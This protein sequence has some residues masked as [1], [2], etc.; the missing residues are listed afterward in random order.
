MTTV[1]VFAPAK[2]NLALHVTGQRA[3]GYHELDTLVT[4]AGAGDHLRISPYPVSSITVEGPEA[5]GVPTD[6]DNLAFKAAWLASPDQGYSILLDK[7]LPVASGIGGGS[8]DAA[9]AFRAALMMGGPGEARAETYWAMPEAVLGTYATALVGLGADVPMCLMSA[10]LRARGVGEKIEFVSL[11]PVHAVL[12]NPRVPVATPDVFRALARKANGRLPELPGA[13]QDAAALI[14]WLQGARN[15][16]ETPAL[17]V[18]PVI[19]DVLSSLRGLDGAG[20]VRMSGSGATCFALFADEADARAGAK[21][22]REARPDW[23]VV[24]T[25]L[26]NWSREAMPR[27]S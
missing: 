17:S 18:A 3:D 21:A 13:F 2:I 12:A 22:L 14:D 24:G 23:W 15:D 7:Q 5:G 8:T 4:F 10:P 16:L 27:L 1:N 19:G 9:A 6:T 25:R 20:L 26:G 11:P